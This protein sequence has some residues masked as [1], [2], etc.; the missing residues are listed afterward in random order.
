[1][2]L[3]GAVA[4]G[5]NQ[6]RPRVHTSQA[7]GMRRHAG[8]LGEPCTRV[9]QHHLPAGHARG[10]QPPAN[11][12]LQL[13]HTPCYLPLPH[14]KVDACTN[15]LRSNPLIPSQCPGLLHTIA[16]QNR[17]DSQT[18]S[19]VSETHVKKVIRAASGPRQVDM[20]PNGEA[21]IRQLPLGPAAFDM[22]L[23]ALPSFPYWAISY[24][25]GHTF[26]VRSPKWSPKGAGGCT[27][28]QL[29]LCQGLAKA[30]WPLTIPNMQCCLW[31]LWSRSCSPGPHSL[32]AFPFVDLKYTNTSF[33]PQTWK[34]LGRRI[35]II[36]IQGRLLPSGSLPHC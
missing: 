15:H 26:M 1:M 30:T 24:W 4:A 7:A 33:S 36:L 10:Y 32:P 12:A 5:G 28:C 14:A 20:S 17:R 25:A 35:Q 6:V 13:L 29:H 2:T 9:Q 31:G 3:A 18:I 16:Q 11:A 21:V 19:E 34:H 23:Q 27:H 22:F 8:L